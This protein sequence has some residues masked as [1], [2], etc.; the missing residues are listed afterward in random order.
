MSRCISDLSVDIEKSIINKI[1]E[2]KLFSLQ[3]DESTDTG[4]K[5]QLLAFT[6]F[7]EDDEILQ[8]FLCF[9]EFEKTTTGKDVF[10]I[11]N[12]YFNTNGLS[13]KSCVRVCT[14]GAPTMIGTI[15]GFV[16]YAKKEN[17]NI[18]TTHCFIQRESLVTKTIGR[19]LK[20]V[21]EEIIKMVNC[22]KA[23]PLK[24]RIF[25]KLCEEMQSHHNNLL[26]HTKMRWLSKG[27]V[28]NRVFELK[29]EI[30]IFFQHENKPE[31]CVLLQN[32]SWC[33]K[34]SLFNRH[35]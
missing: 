8:E 4:G 3:L 12:A 5:A 30:L 17:E 29:E 20:R 2:S 26:L 28:L 32:G 13:W 31:F 21:L 19:E 16:S 11:V 9:K 15:K 1:I 25:A 33:S 6:R 14:D 22:I 24:S 23:R 34:L 18:V 27:R 7:I 10:D 35:I